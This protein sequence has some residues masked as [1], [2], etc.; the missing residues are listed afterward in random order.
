VNERRPNPWRWLT[1]ARLTYA[2]K[3]LMVVAIGL[4]LADAL[5][6]FLDR[7][8]TI[9]YILVGAI[10]FAYL[11]FPAVHRLERRMPR[12]LAILTVYLGIAVTLS[13]AGWL[14]VPRVVDDISQLVAHYPDAMAQINAFVN[15]PQ[16]PIAA[17]LPEWMRA[18]LAKVPEQV[19]E[20]S[21]LHGLET[22]GHAVYILLGTVAALATFVIIPLF[23]AYLLLEMDNLK[24]A[25]MA[26]IPAERLRPTLHLLDEVDDVIGG[27]IRGQLLVGLSVGVL[28]T[29]ALALLHVRYAFLLGLLA[30]V[31]DLIPYVGA[32]LAFTPSFLIALLNNGLGNAVI[33]GVVFLLIFEVEG[34]LIAPNI[35][36]RQVRVSPLIVLIALLVGGEMAGIVGMLVAVP[37]AGILRVIVSHM[38]GVQHER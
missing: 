12:L 31:G 33:V 28:I 21:K 5:V 27:F 11:I 7:V 17:R 23:T 10:F 32:V 3:L 9:F 19:I 14:I 15:D 16:N 26:M 30:A 34:H 38:F 18:E 37:I 1:D 29:I 24:R 35:V 6:G 20:W 8:H 22:A 25:F 36:S 13:L 4:Y 2:L